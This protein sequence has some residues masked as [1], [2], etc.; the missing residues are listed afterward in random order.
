MIKNNIKKRVPLLLLQKILKKKLNGWMKPCEMR[1]ILLDRLDPRQH[2]RIVMS[3]QIL[4]K[5]KNFE[6]QGL[7]QP[8]EPC[9]FQ[10]LLHAILSRHIFPKLPGSEHGEASVDRDLLTRS[11]QARTPRGYPTPTPTHGFMS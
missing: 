6:P 11:L 7:S 4:F 9:P 1:E 5:V 10:S 2:I 3:K 8:I